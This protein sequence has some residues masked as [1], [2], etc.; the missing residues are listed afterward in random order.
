[1]VNLTIYK[2][3]FW[4]VGKAA[5]LI[6]FAAASMMMGSCENF[7]DIEKYVYDQTTRDS[8]FLSRERTDQR[9]GILDP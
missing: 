3:K 1:M 5:S 7:L 2:K 8:I 4:Q 9:C 6:A